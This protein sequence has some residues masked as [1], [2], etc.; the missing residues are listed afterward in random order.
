MALSLLGPTTQRR[1]ARLH[2]VSRAAIFQVASQSGDLKITVPIFATTEETGQQG[3]RAIDELAESFTLTVVAFTGSA[4][5][6]PAV[7]D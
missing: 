1:L 3:R 6:P 4:G 7:L 2:G 5:F